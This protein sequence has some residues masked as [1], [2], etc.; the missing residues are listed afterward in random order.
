MGDEKRKESREE[1]ND[2]KYV[3]GVLFVPHT[4]NSELAKRIREKL[5]S[6][7]EISCIRIRIVKRIGE[8]LMDIIHKSNPWKAIHCDREDCMFCNSS[9]EKLIGK[10]KKRNIVYE[11]E[12]LLSKGEKGE[13]DG[14]EREKKGADIPSSQYSLKHGMVKEYL[15]LGET[16]KEKDGADMLISQYGSNHGMVK[17]YIKE[18]DSKKRKANDEETSE[19]QTEVRATPVKYIGEI[20]RSAMRD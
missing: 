14:R 2:A 13:E 19:T 5:R 8:K 4:E 7:E 6:F 20:S 3:R 16:E 17:E 10:C 18:V 1:E 15:K 11:T 12:C 9:E